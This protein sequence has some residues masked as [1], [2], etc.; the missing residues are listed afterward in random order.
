MARITFRKILRSN[1]V[2]VTVDGVPCITIQ[3]ESI[4]SDTPCFWY[5]RYM[6]AF[7]NTSSRRAPNLA[8]AKEE[9]RNWVNSRESSARTAT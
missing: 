1:L 7:E 2:Q 3:R 5:G 6:G 8:A 9:V 4:F